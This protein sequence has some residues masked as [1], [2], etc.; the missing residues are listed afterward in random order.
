M[1]ARSSKLA[2]IAALFL[3]AATIACGVDIP[4]TFVTTPTV[5]GSATPTA[6]PSSTATE[7]SPTLTPAPT[8]TNTP[9]PSL[10]PSATLS[11]EEKKQKLMDLL[12]TN[13]GCD[14][15][16]WWGIQPGTT[17]TQ[18]GLILLA[19]SGER[20]RPCLGPGPHCYR[21]N[22]FLNPDSLGDVGVEIYD[23]KSTIERIGVTFTEPAGRVDYADALEQFDLKQILRRYG[24][25]RCCTDSEPPG[26]GW[27][28]CGLSSLDSL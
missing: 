20:A 24:T 23:V 1:S 13:G 11:P 4:Q 2:S 28:C 10:T 21:L 27:Q 16:C 12:R 25:I 3:L 15:P 22:L 5:G 26:G 9:R 8:T 19:E 17:S 14:F 6:I 7:E 18:D